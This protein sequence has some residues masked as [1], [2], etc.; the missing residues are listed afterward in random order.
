ML[1]TAQDHI[2]WK[3]CL[4]PLGKEKIETGKL[5]NHPTTFGCRGAGPG[6]N[7]RELSDRLTA[8]QGEL[9]QLEA[10]ER[11]LDEH[12]AWAQQSLLNI[13]E[14]AA[15]V[16]H[17]YL[18]IKTLHSCFQGSG[19]TLL[20]LRG[21]PDTFIRVPDLRQVCAVLAVMLMNSIPSWCPKFFL[22]FLIIWRCTLF[23]CLVVLLTPYAP[24]PPITSFDRCTSSWVC[25][26]F[27]G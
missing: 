3:P 23:L 12:K 7:T 11:T 14:D 26:G 20:S 27:P 9:E 6:C 2:S 5:W 18:P 24:Q 1:I 10:V 4:V 15:N 8:L 21:P 19:S 17:A 25:G 16:A 22:A 13:T